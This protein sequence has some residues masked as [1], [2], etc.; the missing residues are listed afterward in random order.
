[1]SGLARSRNLLALIRQSLE[2]LADSADKPLLESM[3]VNYLLTCAYAD[4]EIEIRS[5]LARYGQEWT[6]ESRV[7]SFIDV[8]IKRVVRSIKCSELAG[9]LGMF[10]A[11]CKKHFQDRINGTP[12]QA[13]YDRIVN[14]RHDQSHSLGSSMTLDDFSE[15]LDKCDVILAALSEALECSCSH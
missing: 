9:T 10:D 4:L 7:H 12:E 8:A 15:D 3:V 1:M 6:K 13:A 14:G 2:P 5:V 11:D